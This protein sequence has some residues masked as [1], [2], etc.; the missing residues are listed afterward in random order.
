MN[1]TGAPHT[2]SHYL[3][4]TLPL[5]FTPAPLESHSHSL[6]RAQHPLPA[7]PSQAYVII[8]GVLAPSEAEMAW[9]GACMAGADGWLNV[10]VGIVRESFGR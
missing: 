3:S 1:R 10:C 8:Q 6:S 4:T 9:L 2:L 5:L 7:P